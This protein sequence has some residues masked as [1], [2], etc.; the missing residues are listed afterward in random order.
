MKFPDHVSLLRRSWWIV[1]TAALIGTAVAVAITANAPRVFESSTELFVSVS[2]ATT[3][4]VQE[5][6]QGSTAAQQKTKGYAEV[7][8]S[9]R[10][11]EPVI[12][13][14]ALDRTPTELARAM[15]VTT[16]TNS[17]TLSITVRDTD[18]ARAAATAGAIADS[19]RHFVTTRLDP[20]PDGQPSLVGIEVLEPATAAT[21]PVSP[22]P[23]VNVGLGVVLGGLLGYGAVFSRRL[24]DTKVR[25][26]RSIDETVDASVLGTVLHDPSASTR[27]L[28]VRVEPRGPKAEAY[29]ALR[30]NLQF[31]GT[32]R[33]ARVIAVSSAMPGEGKTTTSA[34]LAVALA[35]TG[36]RVALV[37][38][39]LRRPRV[40][41]VMGLEG[42]VGLSDLLVGRA[43]LSDVAQPWGRVSLDVIPA[44]Q[45]PPNSSELLGSSSMEHLLGELRTR[46]DYVLLDAPPLLPVTDAAVLSQLTDGVLVVA[47]TARTKKT[48]LAEAIEALHQIGSRVLGVVLTM[49]PAKHSGAYDTAYAYA[50]DRD[51][52]PVPPT[53][54]SP[55]RAARPRARARARA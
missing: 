1:L 53:T 10:V 36:A 39:D 2:G 28:T 55:R 11:L 44:G 29:R 34:N 40:A 16:G 24:L 7:A 37:D 25:D 50:Y 46:Y 23:V 9:S 12:R 26:R 30:T 8:T 42:A 22:R 19:L 51:A 13:D 45:I 38:A 18:S 33:P 4:T 47:A 32:G 20:A 48:Q 27:P 35:E 41:A 6:G 31:V 43:E 15:T 5:V 21:S 52:R 17:V 54:T 14:L 49:Q 3:A